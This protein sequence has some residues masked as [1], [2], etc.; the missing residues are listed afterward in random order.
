MQTHICP[1]YIQTATSTDNKEC[2]TLS[3]CIS[4]ILLTE[5]IYLTCKHMH[6][7]F[8]NRNFPHGL[9]ACPTD[10]QS[11]AIIILSILTGQNLCTNMA[12][13]AILC[14]LTLTEIPRGVEAYVFTGQILYLSPNWQR[15]EGK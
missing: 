12:L 5:Y 15:T 10:F 8:F 9:T 3:A 1:T 11:T 14:L 7:Q 2:L 6:T 4:T 13:W